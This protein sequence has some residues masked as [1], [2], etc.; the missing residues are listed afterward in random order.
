MAKNPKLRTK[1]IACRREKV[2][3]KVSSFCI[4]FVCSTIVLPKRL[5]FSKAL[6]AASSGLQ[7][8]P[9]QQLEA[10][11][12]VLQLYLLPYGDRKNLDCMKTALAHRR[13]KS[14]NK[15]R[16]PG[17]PSFFAFFVPAVIE[18]FKKERRPFLRT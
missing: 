11:K 13:N 6:R 9:F 18:A 17:Q 12:Y 1:E 10:V 15:E 16:R 2:P 5:K 3:E 4:H 14:K 7:L 8:R